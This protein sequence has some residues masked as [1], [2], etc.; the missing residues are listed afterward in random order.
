MRTLISHLHLAPSRPAGPSLLAT[1]SALGLS[2]P[3]SDRTT[4]G[5]HHDSVYRSRFVPSRRFPPCPLPRPPHLCTN[6]TFADPFHFGFY[7]NQDANEYGIATNFT[8][9][10]E[11][12]GKAGYATHMIGKW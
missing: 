12:L 5:A 7:T 10:P 3:P 1:P 8:M 6:G 9:L 2:P 11:L 4:A